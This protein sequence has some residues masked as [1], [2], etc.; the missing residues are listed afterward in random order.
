MTNQE[1]ERRFE[2]DLAIKVFKEN[3]PESSIYENIIFKIDRNNIEKT[4]K[5]IKILLNECKYKS[6]CNQS[7]TEIVKII[8][9]FNGYEIIII[10]SKRKLFDIDLMGTSIKNVLNDIPDYIN[11]VDYNF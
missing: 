10:D 4:Y 7:F 1:I 6:Y 11:D 3:F 9:R 5:F 8:N 2:F